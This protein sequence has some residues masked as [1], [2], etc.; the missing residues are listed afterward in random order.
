MNVLIS[1]TGCLAPSTEMDSFLRRSSVTRG[2]KR[3]LLPARR[4]TSCDQRVFRVAKGV[5]SADYCSR[6]NVLVTGSA[7]RHLRV[8]NPFM[9]SCAAMN[10]NQ[11]YIQE[12]LPQ[13]NKVL[14]KKARIFRVA[15]YIGVQQ[16]SLF[17]ASSML[18]YK[19]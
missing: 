6:H 8:W 2:S 7:D 15:S 14:C 9:T 16:K 1:D 11:C 18:Y 13:F 19:L 4:L 3:G 10:L 12:Q 5:S 17:I